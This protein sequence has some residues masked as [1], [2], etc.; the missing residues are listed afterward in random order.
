MRENLIPVLASL[1]FI[2]QVVMVLLG[3]IHLLTASTLIRVSVILLSVGLVCLNLL[4]I[5][6]NYE[7]YGWFNVV[8]YTV[9][10]VLFCFLL[11]E[12][13]RSNHVKR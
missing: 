3:V 5:V 13:R 9:V 10:A 12:N 11:W 1:N 2:L 8:A 7:S 4:F 6:P